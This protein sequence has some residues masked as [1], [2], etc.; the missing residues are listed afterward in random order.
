VLLLIFILHNKIQQSQDESSTKDKQESTTALSPH[1]AS[2]NVIVKT[3][4][5]ETHQSYMKEFSL[6][7]FMY[8]SQ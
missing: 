3:V 7:S 6:V 4:T 8:P 2:H 5:V 1:E